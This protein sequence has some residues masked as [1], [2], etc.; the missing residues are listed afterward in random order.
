VADKPRW[1]RASEAIS[2]SEASHGRLGQDMH[3]IV[4]RLFNSISRRDTGELWIAKRDVQFHTE[5]DFAGITSYNKMF[6]R[7]NM[8]LAT[9]L[10]QLSDGIID[11]DR[12]SEFYPATAIAERVYSMP[13]AAA[14]IA[15][16]IAVDYSQFT[17]LSSQVLGAF[18]MGPKM[19]FDTSVWNERVGRGDY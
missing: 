3:S 5:A 16:R 12:F 17:N 15:K 18:E 2:E 1:L 4:Q 10:L 11:D 14:A 9:L 7:A 8:P 19:I 6:L 13:G